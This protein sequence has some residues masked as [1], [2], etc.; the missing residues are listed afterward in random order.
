MRDVF[1][2]EKTES[3]FVKQPDKLVERRPRNNQLVKLFK[4]YTVNVCVCARVYRI[5]LWQAGDLEQTFK[6]EGT[7]ENLKFNKP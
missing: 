5:V 2:N 1:I 3:E 7:M 6:K 4:V